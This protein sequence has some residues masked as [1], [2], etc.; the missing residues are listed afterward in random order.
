MKK[1]FITLSVLFLVMLNNNATASDSNNYLNKITGKKWQKK[2]LKEKQS[3]GS[4]CAD[5]FFEC[6]K[7]VEEDEKKEESEKEEA[8]KACKEKAKIC[9]KKTIKTN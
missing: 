5:N 3:L 7:E 6:K 8:K 1:I 4:C 9:R 2:C